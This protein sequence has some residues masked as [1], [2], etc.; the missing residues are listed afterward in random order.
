MM[1]TIVLPALAAGLLSACAHE[2]PA[3]FRGPYFFTCDNDTLLTVRF[4]TA[5][6]TAR[7]IT[8]TGKPFILYYVRAADGYWYS[9]GTRSLRGKGKEA[10][11][12]RPGHV[13]VTCHQQP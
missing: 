10:R 11:W 7:V 12:E 2:A 3:S 1:R 6:G 4:D 5:T 8:T 9:D 13:A